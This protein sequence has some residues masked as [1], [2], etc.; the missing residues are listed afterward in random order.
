MKKYIQNKK[1]NKNKN[2]I[3]KSII[4]NNFNSFSRN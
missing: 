1:Y 2:E 3:L 4:F